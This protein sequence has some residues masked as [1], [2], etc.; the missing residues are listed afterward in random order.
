MSRPPPMHA[1]EHFY[2]NDES[3]CD[4]DT[5]DMDY[6]SDLSKAAPSEH[7]IQEL[8]QDTNDKNQRVHL[9][10]FGTRYTVQPTNVDDLISLMKTSASN[11]T[12][13]IVENICTSWIGKLGAG[14]DLD[15]RFFLNHVASPAGVHLWHTV[16]SRGWN[17]A[18]SH[19]IVEQDDAFHGRQFTFIEGMIPCVV[20]GATENNRIQRRSQ[21]EHR[22][23]WTVTTRISYY[24]VSEHSCRLDRPS[25]A[26]Q[27][28]D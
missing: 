11:S 28:T 6:L 7:P 17:H 10:T 25:L 12:V 26:A 9:H 4:G 20:E 1:V 24:R 15:K 22:Y 16:M 21:W 14:L 2:A 27:C 13:G 19:R 23:G 3:K 18:M 8:L 5:S